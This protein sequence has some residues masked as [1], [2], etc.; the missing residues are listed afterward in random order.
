MRILGTG[1][2]FDSGAIPSL[3]YRRS[4]WLAVRRRTLT[5][6]RPPCRKARVGRRVRMPDGESA[7]RPRGGRAAQT[8]AARPPVKPKPPGSPASRSALFTPSS[9]PHTTSQP[10]RHLPASVGTP[11][12][13][14]S[15][16]QTQNAARPEAPPS[17]PH[18][19]PS[20]ERDT[21]AREDYRVRRSRP[22][23]ADFQKA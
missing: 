1:P 23:G 4:T 9:H 21:T 15:N 8:P 17:H 6:Q 19:R 22:P 16:T 2:S 3:V 20:Q 7:L 10:S 13:I 12:T 11:E 18:A 14:I 5:G